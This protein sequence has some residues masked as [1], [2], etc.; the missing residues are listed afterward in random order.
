MSRRRFVFQPPYLMS[1]RLLTLRT[2]K[3]PSAQ[4][5]VDRRSAKAREPARWCDRLLEDSS[6]RGSLACNPSPVRR[7]LTEGLQKA[8]APPIIGDAAGNQESGPVPA[9]RTS[10]NRSSFYPYS[11][12]YS[13]RVR[14]RVG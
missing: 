13:N 14:A 5:A 7:H 3:R 10:T 1:A 9:G 11:C 2:S 6:P 4:Q 12:S 8:R